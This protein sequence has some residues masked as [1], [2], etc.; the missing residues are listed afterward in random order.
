MSDTKASHVNLSRELADIAEQV[1][2]LNRLI[3][4]FVA[5]TGN[6]AMEI[7]AEIEMIRDCIERFALRYHN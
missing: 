3:N 5:A 6:R 1:E 7:K 2:R 4:E